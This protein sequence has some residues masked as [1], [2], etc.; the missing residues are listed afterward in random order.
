[1]N[2]TT[3]NAIERTDRQLVLRFSNAKPHHIDEYM[4]GSI[5]V[6][7]DDAAGVVS[8]RTSRLAPP[9]MQII[10]DIVRRYNLS[11]DPLVNDLQFAV[12]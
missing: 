2:M 9:E 4:A 6:E 5:L 11:L 1:M 8:I 12:A 3:L 7:I 10:S